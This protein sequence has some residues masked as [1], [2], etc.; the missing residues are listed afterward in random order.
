MAVCKGGDM[1]EIFISYSRENRDAAR[2][3]ADS[4]EAKG[5][6]VWW[7]RELIAGEDFTDKIEQILDTAKA[8]IVLWS[9]SSR[10]SHW[11]RDEAA[12]GRDRNRLLPISID[13]HM[14]PLGFRQVH[15]LSLQGWDGVQQ[16]PLEDLWI[17]L[18]GLVGDPNASSSERTSIEAQAA[19]GAEAS[20]GDVA[21]EETAVSPKKIA[22]GINAAPN[23]KSI[24]QILKE[25]KKQR[26]FLRTY[27]LTSFVISAIA[28]VILGGVSIYADGF[29]NAEASQVQQV[30]IGALTSFI[31]VGIGLIIGRFLIVVGRRLS[32]RK[33]VRYFDQPTLIVLGLSCALGLLLML[34]GNDQS[35]PD[36]TQYSLGDNLYFGPIASLFFFFPFFAAFSIPIGAI[37]GI[38]RKGFQDGA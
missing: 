22:A 26:S 32:K 34:V 31:C 17:G 19:F 2:I 27:W 23:N 28:A 15:T 36:A 1:A 37:R 33:S 7:D 13:Q 6:D 35:D 30:L 24:D 29:N 12:V 25:E 38:G 8:V 5:Y 20:S 21:T 14:P 10:K 18:Q 4:I 3:L 16:E 11:V 9:E